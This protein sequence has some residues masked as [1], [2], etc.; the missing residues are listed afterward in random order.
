MYYINNTLL[1]LLLHYNCST[2][3]TELRRSQRESSEKG[4]R[5]TTTARGP[6]NDPREK[7]RT[8]LHTYKVRQRKEKTPSPP[9]RERISRIST[10]RSE[11]RSFGD[12]SGDATSAPGRSPLP[13]RTLLRLQHCD[14]DYYDTT[15]TIFLPSDRPLWPRPVHCH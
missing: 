2:I 6:W 5:S 8:L 12:A 10:G 14:D 4:H 13:T 9:A 15:N 11:K 1:A 7:V 3:Q